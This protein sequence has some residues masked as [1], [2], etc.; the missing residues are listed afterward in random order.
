M[1]FETIDIDLMQR[2]NLEMNKDQVSTLL[3]QKV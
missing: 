2:I 1:N 3:M